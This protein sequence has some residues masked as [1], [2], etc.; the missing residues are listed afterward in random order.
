MKTWRAL[1]L[2]AAAGCA[3]CGWGCATANTVEGRIERN[4]GFFDSLPLATQARIR[5]GQTELGFTREETLLA[6]GAPS[7]KVVRRDAEG[8]AEV[9][10]YT[11]ASQRFE[12]GRVDFA[13]VPDGRGG[14]LTGGGNVSVLMEREEEV[15]RVE[16]RGGVVT[17]IERT[18]GE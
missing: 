3:A 8:T 10:V 18:A 4:R 9:W 16:F 15:G 13:G 17:A 2:A 12:R 11:A 14:R 7:R 6:L 1:A 5:G